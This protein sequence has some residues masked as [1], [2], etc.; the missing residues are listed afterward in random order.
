MN[1]P[2]TC[3]HSEFKVY[4]KEIWETPS[5][6]TRVADFVRCTKCGDFQ[7]SGE[8]YWLQAKIY[9]LTEA[10]ERQTCLQAVWVKP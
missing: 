7:V 8:S 9:Q 3:L 5:K 10:L 2:S 4:L 1:T 6:P